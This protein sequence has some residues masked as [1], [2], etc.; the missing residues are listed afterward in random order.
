VR[1]HAALATAAREAERVI[2]LFVFDEVL[3]AGPCGAPNRLSFLLDSLRDLDRALRGRGGRLVVRRGDPVEEALGVATEAGA[4]A[5]HLSEDVSGYAA[6]RLERL[7]SAC[8]R[9]RVELRAYAGVTAVPPGSLVPQ[10]GDHY[11]VF[12]PYW[13]QWSE[14]PRSEPAPAP[15]R[16]R[17]PAGVG[18][19]EIPV[20]RELTGGSPSPE[21]REG[22][23]SAARRRL[24]R[25]RPPPSCCRSSA[26]S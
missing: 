16:V 18:G 19:M 4:G 25:E 22:G 5:I 21:L 24:E 1:D 26:S 15:R 17:V 10:G 13:R 3:L 7:R 23:E 2:P 14:V 11:R 20:L 8:E 9:A 6:R 12:T